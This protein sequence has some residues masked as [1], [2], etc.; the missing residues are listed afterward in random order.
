[1]T[2]LLPR[3]SYDAAETVGFVCGPEV[4]MRFGAIALAQRG[5][6]PEH[7]HLSAERSMKCAVGH[8]GHCQYG[9]DFVCKDG[10]VY[11]YPLM[12]PRLRVREL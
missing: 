11:S 1:M 5:V 4:M 12:A 7:I 10:P 3:V 8:C 2:T 9:A 6:P